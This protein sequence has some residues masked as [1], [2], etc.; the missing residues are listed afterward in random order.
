MIQ[1]A[2]VNAFE[3]RMSEGREEERELADVAESERQAQAS[4]EDVDEGRGVDT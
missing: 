3:S 1:A 2:V 4:S